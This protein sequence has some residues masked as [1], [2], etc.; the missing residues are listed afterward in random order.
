[1]DD[2]EDLAH[3]A[4]ADAMSIW[5]EFYDAGTTM[6]I[7]PLVSVP[8]MDQGYYREIDMEYKWPGERAGE[9]NDDL[10]NTP[11]RGEYRPWPDPFPWRMWVDYTKRYEGADGGLKTDLYHWEYLTSSTIIAPSSL[12][13]IEDPAVYEPNIERR[14]ARMTNSPTTEEIAAANLWRSNP[15]E[16]LRRLL[17]NEAGSKHGVNCDLLQP[18]VMNHA[19][20]YGYEFKLVLD[21]NPIFAP[22]DM[23]HPEWY[24]LLDENGQQLPDEIKEHRLSLLNNGAYRLYLRPANWRWVGKVYANYLYVSWF[25]MFPTREVFTTAWFNRPPIYPWR[26]DL[27]HSTQTAPIEYLHNYYSIDYGIEYGF[28]SSRGAQFLRDQIISA[29]WWRM[30]EAYIFTGNDPATLILWLYPP[31]QGDIVL[32]VG[33][34][35][36]ITGAEKMFWVRQNRDLT[37]EYQRT[38]IGNYIIL[39][40]QVTN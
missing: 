36:H 17:Y 4:G 39:N 40:F 38:V 12:A 28:N 31:E 27:I 23:R 13:Q 14:Y 11:L 15:T 30:S 34:L 9:I 10:I 35:D 2:A 25:E 6:V 1:V 5:A 20:H 24:D 32:G 21:Y 19:A 18:L 7:D 26:H 8:G 16:Y 22:V 37:D 3:P 29:Q 33:E